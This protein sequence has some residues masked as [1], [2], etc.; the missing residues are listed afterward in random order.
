VFSFSFQEFAGS[1]DTYNMKSYIQHLIIDLQAW[2]Q[3]KISVD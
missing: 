2:Y 3:F 1:H